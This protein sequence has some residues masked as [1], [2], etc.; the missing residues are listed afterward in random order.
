[1]VSCVCFSWKMT[2]KQASKAWHVD[3]AEY[4]VSTLRGIVCLDIWHHHALD[5]ATSVQFA[6]DVISM[7]RTFKYTLLNRLILRL[8]LQ[9]KKKSNEMIRW[10]L[11]TLI[12][13]CSIEW[14]R[15]ARDREKSKHSHYEMQFICFAFFDFVS[16]FHYIFASVCVQ[17]NSMNCSW[18]DCVASTPPQYLLA[19]P[20][21]ESI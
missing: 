20:A 1:M 4:Q 19:F 17:W 12:Y 5:S 21:C 8:R 16:F 6:C 18:I 2:N 13:N 7:V 9:K 3:P 15:S 10:K 14:Q 11:F